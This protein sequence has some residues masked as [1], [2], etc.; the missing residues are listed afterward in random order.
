VRR[1]GVAS[2][3]R[4]KKLCKKTKM[5]RFVA[6]A[7]CNRGEDCLFAH[8]VEDL[9]AMPDLSRTKMCRTL[10]V[11]GNCTDPYCAFTHSKTEMRTAL[12]KG[13]CSTLRSTVPMQPSLLLKPLQS[14]QSEDCE[15]GKQFED[16][17]N[18]VGEAVD[19]IQTY[20]QESPLVEHSVCV[21]NTFLTVEF[22]VECRLRQSQSAPPR[23]VQ[24][25]GTTKLVPRFPVESPWGVVRPSSPPPRA[26]KQG[27]NPGLLLEAM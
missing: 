3:R 24:I 4:L 21:K 9:A 17:K 26:R 25:E 12:A 14:I 5:C 11:T 19:A 7:A 22:A 23:L 10:R 20:C 1:A 16:V 13:K 15:P 8:S 6:K 2:E 18:K 27:S